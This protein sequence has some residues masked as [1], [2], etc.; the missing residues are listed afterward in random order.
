MK[1]SDQPGRILAITVV[2][3]FLALVSAELFTGVFGGLARFIFATVLA[4]LSVLFFH[5]EIFWVIKYPGKLSCVHGTL[6][7]VPNVKP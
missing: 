4:V 5:Y 3:P 6:V 2:A 1:V 7:C